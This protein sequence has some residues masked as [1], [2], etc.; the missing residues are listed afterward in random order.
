MKAHGERDSCK[1]SFVHP[2]INNGYC[3]LQRASVAWPLS[4]VITAFTDVVHKGSDRSKQP[5]K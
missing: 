4:N 3:S 1:D 2:G 5:L